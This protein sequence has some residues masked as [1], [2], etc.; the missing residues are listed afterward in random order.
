PMPE[1]RKGNMSNAYRISIIRLRILRSSFG[2]SFVGGR[3]TISCGV[4]DK[5][6]ISDWVDLSLFVA[7]GSTSHKQ[8]NL[9]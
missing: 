8:A 6:T 3:R 4:A 2:G 5:G 1:E 9:V 7:I